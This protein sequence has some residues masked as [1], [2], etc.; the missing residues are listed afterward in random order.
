MLYRF[1]HLSATWLVACTSEGLL[2]RSGVISS[3]ACYKSTDTF[4]IVNY[5]S[6]IIFTFLC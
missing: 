6:T 4:L 3:F 1:G 5:L 2:V